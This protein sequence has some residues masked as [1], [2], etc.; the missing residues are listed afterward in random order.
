MSSQLA[1]WLLH[2]AALNQVKVLPGF[3]LRRSDPLIPR[4]LVQLSS[5]LATPLTI[6]VLPLPSFRVNTAPY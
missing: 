3:E 5:Q 2:P 1:P 4:L 6:V